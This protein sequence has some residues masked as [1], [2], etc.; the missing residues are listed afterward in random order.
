MDVCLASLLWLELE[1]HYPEM[2]EPYARHR[3][4]AEA[5][6]NQLLGLV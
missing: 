2:A 6:T 4:F 1:Q 5:R 3:I